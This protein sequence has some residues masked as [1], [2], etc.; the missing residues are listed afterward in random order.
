MRRQHENIRFV[1]D[2]SHV[3]EC[4]SNQYA[5]EEIFINTL[6]SLEEEYKRKYKYNSLLFLQE[7]SNILVINKDKKLEN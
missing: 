7:K 2:W 3:W 1:E 4:P 6:I 5:E